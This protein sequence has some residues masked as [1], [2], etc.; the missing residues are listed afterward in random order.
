MSSSCGWRPRRRL[1]GLVH[2][3]VLRGLCR[4]HVCRVVVCSVARAVCALRAPSQR[5]P[6]GSLE[7]GLEAR[8]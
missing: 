3:C 7:A 4:G 8:P 1:A 2:C 6:V 5:S